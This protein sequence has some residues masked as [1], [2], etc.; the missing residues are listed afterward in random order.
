MRAR[1]VRISGD[2][3]NG[4]LVHV[5][6]ARDGELEAALDLED[7]NELVSLKVY[8]NWSLRGGNVSA[9]IPGGGS[10][11]IARVLTDARPGQ[12]VV[13]HDGDK[14]NLTRKNLSCSESGF[15]VN[16]DREM[17]LN[18]AKRLEEEKRLAQEAGSYHPRY[19]R[20]EPLSQSEPRRPLSRRDRVAARRGS[21]NPPDYAMM[22][23]S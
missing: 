1:P 2:Q 12:R 19:Q 20:P 9:R 8:P 14:L 10:V 13:Y 21:F 23:H 18:A 15:A 22:R 16:H 7:Y 3:D 17:V 4:F 11:L 6:L 5:P